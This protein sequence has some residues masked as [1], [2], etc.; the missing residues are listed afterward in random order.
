MNQN[1]DMNIF[2]I[3]FEKQAKIWQEIASDLRRL[4]QIDESST[5]ALKISNDYLLL[6]ERVND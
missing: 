4:N 3:Y 2:N 5:R 1:I 6:S